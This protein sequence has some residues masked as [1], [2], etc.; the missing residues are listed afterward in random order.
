MTE[1]TATLN[2]VSM[3]LVLQD[4]S[5][6]DGYSFGADCSISGECVFQTGALASPSFLMFRHDKLCRVL[7]RPLIQRAN[8]GIIVSTHR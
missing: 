7:D 3:A 4:G 1:A 6:F 2:P 8:S 5:R